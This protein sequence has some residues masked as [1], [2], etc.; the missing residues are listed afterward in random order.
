MG[1]HPL[2][3]HT[4]AEAPPS[5]SPLS[6]FK[7]RGVA[8]NIEGRACKTALKGKKTETP[9]EGNNRVTVYATIVSILNLFLYPESCPAH[10]ESV[11]ILDVIKCSDIRSEHYRIL[12]VLKHPVFQLP[13]F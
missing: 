5:V 13:F 7:G 8:H 6:N 11:I 12:E 4:F 3:A 10:Q 1:L 9:A 2:V